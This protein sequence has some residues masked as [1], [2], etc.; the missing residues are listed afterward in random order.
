MD[1]EGLFNAS[2]MD[3]RYI[4]IVDVYVQSALFNTI[5]RKMSGIEMPDDGLELNKFSFSNSRPYCYLDRE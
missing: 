2:C 1:Q 4:M 5:Y 3:Y